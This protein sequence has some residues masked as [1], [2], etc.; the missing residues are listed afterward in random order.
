MLPDEER[1][2][3]LEVAK[4]DELKHYQN[5][6]NLTVGKGDFTIASHLAIEGT[7]ESFCPFAYQILRKI[8]P[9][10]RKFL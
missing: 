1:I 3:V 5:G 7:K 6:H 10:H 4:R 9:R 2:V 8:H